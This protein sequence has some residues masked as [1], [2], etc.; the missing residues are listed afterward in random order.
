MKRLG[1][2]LC[3]VNMV[4][5]ESGNRFVSKWRIAITGAVF[6]FGGCATMVSRKEFS[7][8]LAKVPFM[9]SVSYRHFE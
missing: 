6:L 4:C 7:F 1:V 5:P 9:K 8:P 3:C 2:S